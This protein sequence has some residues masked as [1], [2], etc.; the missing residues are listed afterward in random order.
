MLRHLSRG[1][2]TSA[3]LGLAAITFVTPPTALAGRDDRHDDRGGGG[4]DRGE[5]YR[6]HYKGRDR[7][8][9][10][11]GDRE[12]A[13]ERRETRVWVEPVYRTVCER[14]WVEPVYRTVV[15]RVWREPEY[16]EEHDRVWVPGRWELRE[17]VCYERGRRV[18]HRE[19]VLVEPAHWEVRTHRVL[20]CE[21]RWETIE[22][23]ELVC[24]GH[25]KNLERQE[26]VREG[27]WEYRTERVAVNDGWNGSSIDVRFAR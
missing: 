5:R 19:R 13:Y 1:A 9:L 10:R 12:P 18:I 3:V 8:D 22:R 21:G 11:I 23:R 17:R 14:V 16:R 6:E 4:A 27:H 25:W 7:G 15:D 20:V 26:L 2:V 24:E